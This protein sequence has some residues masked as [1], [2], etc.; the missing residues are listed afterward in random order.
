MGTNAT[1]APSA[2]PPLSTVERI[3]NVFF[4]PSKTFT[5]LNR[6]NSW[7][8][9]WL[10]IA[11]FAFLFVFAVQKQV[12]WEQITKNEIAASQKAQDRM[13]KLNPEQRDQSIQVQSNIG[14]YISYC[15]PIFQLFIAAIV[16]AVLMATFNFGLGTEI[17]FNTALAIVF[18]GWIPGILK[19]VLVAISLFAG[20]DPEGFNVNNPVA[21]NLGYF[22][23][24]ADHPALAG[25]LSWFD[26]F[27]IWYI[28]LFGIGFSCVSRVKRGTAIGVVAGWCALIALVGAGFRAIFS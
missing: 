16:A 24:R 8:P 7:W 19:S 20:A 3:T 9:A 4:A 21:T 28:I 11:V 5:D 1:S 17:K 18:Y 25:L 27:T 23:N 6:D 2:P 12:G 15:I 14:K 22:I 10:L 26:I 13:E